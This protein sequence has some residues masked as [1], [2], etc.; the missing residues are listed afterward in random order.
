MYT[1]G[2]MSAEPERFLGEVAQQVIGHFSFEWLHVYS[3]LNP[4]PK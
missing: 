4:R 2:R 3:E 1:G